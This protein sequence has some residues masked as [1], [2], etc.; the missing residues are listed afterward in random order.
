MTKQDTDVTK[1]MHGTPTIPTGRARWMMILLLLAMNINASFIQS[2]MNVALDRI[3]S[4]FSV[5]LAVANWVVLGYAI[6]VGTVITMSTSL[7]ER[8]GVRKVM[9]AGMVFACAGSLLGFFAANFPMLL[10][11]RLV[12]AVTTGLSFPVVTSA[13]MTLAPNGK[14]GMLMSVNS[15]V[16]GF[17]LA[18]APSLSGLVITY[19]SLQALFLLPAV[20]SAV[21]FAAGFFLLHDLHER[22]DK[23]IDIP[24]V[25]MSLVIM[26]TF[27]YG[28]NEV[29]RAPAMSL[30]LMGVAVAVGVLFVLRERKLPDPLLNLAPLKTGI[31]SLGELLIVFAYMC[32]LFLSLLAPL[33]LEGTAGYTPFVAGC[34]L[35]LPIACYA[36]ACFISGIIGKSHGV[37]PLVPVGFALTA[38][39]YAALFFVSSSHLMLA[40]LVA[41][42]V[43]YTGI[44]L[45][46]PVIKSANL[47]ALPKPLSSSGASIHSTVVQIAGSISSA[48]FVGIMSTDVASSM[49]RGATKAE[50]YAT[51][52]SHTLLIALGILVVAVVVSV[53]YARLVV[54]REGKLI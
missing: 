42:A 43:S 1:A 13:L 26:A 22:R 33:F 15:A 29:T 8:Y 10:V 38:I 2:S 53:F 5:R 34:M 14:A 19:Q 49:A 28:L 18:I 48:L 12:Q 6:I 52:F 47:E 46:F 21:L 41:V 51:G 54:D 31:F 25:F 4:D 30:V 45:V 17:G 16:I 44:G 50:A 36:I 40:F 11:A 7:L 24:S 35:A 39:G 3:S 20:V 27:M 9:L 23:K 32:S 37:W